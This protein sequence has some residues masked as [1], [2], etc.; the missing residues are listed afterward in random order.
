MRENFQTQVV[1][2]P[3]M[4][5]CAMHLE[6]RLIENAPEVFKQVLHYAKILFGSRST[7][8]FQPNSLRM[9]LAQKIGGSKRNYFLTDI[10]E[11]YIY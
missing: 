4:M 5:H 3:C 10:G 9:H 1:T 8:G 7:M 2:L 6:K 11:L